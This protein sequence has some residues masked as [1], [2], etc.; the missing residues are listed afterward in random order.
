MH[1]VAPS[2]LAFT[3]MHGLGNDFVVVDARKRAFEPDAALVR[4][5]ANRRSGVGFDQLLVIGKAGKG[6]AFAYRVWNADGGE[7]EQCGNGARCLALLW[8]TALSPGAQEF[9]MSSAAGPV[10]ARVADGEA[11]VSLG[12]PAFAPDRIPMKAT[13]EAPRYTIDADAMRIELGAVSMGNPHAL[14]TVDDI[15][16]APVTTLGPLVERHPAFPQ[17]VNVGFAQ[18]LDRAHLALRVWERGCGETEACGTAACAAVAVLRDRGELDQ[19]VSVRLPGGALAVDWP[20]RGEAIWLSG[21]AARV[22]EGTI[23]L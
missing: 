12:I 11:A 15:G 21:P 1:Q 13:S 16:A 7:V 14:I 2:T 8:A 6:R 19:R 3:K 10:P 23:S 5:L 4:R 22:F 17:R 20:G 18:V 9:T